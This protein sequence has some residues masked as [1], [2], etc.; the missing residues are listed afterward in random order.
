LSDSAP[1]LAGAGGL[2]TEGSQSTHAGRKALLL[3]RDSET[4]EF[5]ALAE[6]MGIEIV[7]IIE[8]RGKANPRTH[9]GSGRLASIH[10]DLSMQPSGHIWTGVDLAL[11]HANLLPR[12]IVELTD[13]LGI[14]VWDRVRLLLELFTRHASSVEARTQV[15]IARLTA[16]RNILR[17]LTRRETSGERLGWGAGG[18]TGWNAVLETVAAE[19]TSLRRKRDRGVLAVRERQRQRSA[20]GART[21]GFAGYTNAGKSS[22]FQ[23]LTNKPVL[24][25]DK[26]FST[27]ETTVGRMEKS[28]RVL[29]IDTIGFIDAVPASLLDAFRATLD[30][31]LECDLLLLIIDASDSVVEVERRFATSRRELMERSE[32]RT[33]QPLEVVLTKSDRCSDSHLA[34]VLTTIESLGHDKPIICSAKSGEGINSLR[35]RILTQLH[36]PCRTFQLFHPVEQNKPPIAALESAVRKEMMVLERSIEDYGIELQGWIGEAAWQR[37]L[38]E[39]PDRIK[40]HP[41]DVSEA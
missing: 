10:D 27:L 6:T 17:E 18:R 33:A 4:K 23:L 40:L 29:L 8:Q 24:V 14:E 31:S 2:L 30:E 35:Q 36:G 7:E 9:L 38:L 19:I 3:T 22:L 1:L 28:P 39:F 37:L 25:E 13:A 26:V 5:C 34:A 41:T 20:S 12:Q 15:R 11:I 21:V 16:D 32:A